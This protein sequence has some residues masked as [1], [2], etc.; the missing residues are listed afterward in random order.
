MDKCMPGCSKYYIKGTNPDFG[1]RS[2]I[3]GSIMFAS[4]SGPKNGSLQ[5]GLEEYYDKYIRMYKQKIRHL[6]KNADLYHVLPRPD[7]VNWDGI[8][9]IDDDS[10]NEIKGALFVFKPSEQG[11]KT[12]TIKLRGL[13]P[14][15]RYTLESEDNSAVKFNMT[16]RDLMNIGVTLTLNDAVDSDIIWI[17]HAQ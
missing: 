14:K 2:V 11:G 9:Y 10:E 15:Q 5:F 6:A 1:F 3:M 16:G 13:D 8:Q 17:K 7:G 12:K 4:W